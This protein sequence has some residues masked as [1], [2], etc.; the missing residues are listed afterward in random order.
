MWVC[1]YETDRQT[2]RCVGDFPAVE[3]CSHTG[4]YEIS[5]GPEPWE[6]KGRTEENAMEKEK[7]AG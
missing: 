3:S 2:D 5:F 1:M 6:Q 4:L 7:Q